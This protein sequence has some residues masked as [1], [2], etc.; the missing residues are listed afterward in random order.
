ME[1]SKKCTKCGTE[2][3][4][5]EFHKHKKTKDGYNWICKDC[6]RV[7]AKNYREKNKDFVAQRK[8]EYYEKNILSIKAKR[9]VYRE[10]NRE[11]IN[12][13]KRLSH[14][15][16][17]ESDPVYKLKILLRKRLCNFMTRG[18]FPKT[19]S[20]ADTLGCT[21]EEL[22]KHIEKQFTKGMTWDNQGKW[23]IDHI[24]PLASATTEE[25]V[26]K[27]NHYT[28]LQPLWAEDN[29]RKGAKI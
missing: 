13:Q 12:N 10:I 6:K 16:K 11:K 24:I 8:K 19:T 23:H 20:T 25:E 27:L 3:A 26:Y 21:W 15:K 1:I 7:Q 5:S 14:N 4:L 9:K 22:K 2:K 28:N 17:A 29:L 18:G